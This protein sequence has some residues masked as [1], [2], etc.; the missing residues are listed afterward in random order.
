VV[1]LNYDTVAERAIELASGEGDLQVRLF[2]AVPDSDLGACAY[3]WNRRLAL[4]FR[5][6]QVTMPTV[7]VRRVVPGERYYAAKENALYESCRVIKLHGSIDWLDLRPIEGDT[8]SPASPVGRGIWVTWRDDSLSRPGQRESI[9]HHTVHPV[10]IPPIRNKSLARAP[11]RQLWDLAQAT[12][13]GCRHLTV[14][15]YSFPE[16][17]GLVQ[18]LL[19]NAIAS[20]PPA[21]VTVVDRNERVARRLRDLTAF[22]GEIRWR[23]RLEDAYG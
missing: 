19:R 10:V 11:F 3:R 17:D 1:T 22:A 2:S 21:V 6:D 12:L 4:G 7:G 8:V 13:K 23:S 15:G 20:D 16:T 5:P 18:S 9:G 14:I